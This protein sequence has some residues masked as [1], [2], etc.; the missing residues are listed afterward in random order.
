MLVYGFD[1]EV[2]TFSDTGSSDVLRQMISY[3][4]SYVYVDR[5]AFEAYL[6][7][8]GAGEEAYIVFGGFDKLPGIGGYGYSCYYEAGTGERTAKIPY[9]NPE[10]DW[11]ISLIKLL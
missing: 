1:G 4:D 2:V 11:W 7:E 3:D 10:S 8:H 9:D 6:R 5:E